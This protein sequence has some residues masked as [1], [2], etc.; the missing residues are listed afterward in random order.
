MVFE[1]R[2]PDERLYKSFRLYAFMEGVE[3]ENP[4][5][6]DHCDVVLD[7]MDADWF[8]G[9]AE[10]VPIA[11]EEAG[12]APISIMT[13]EESF[14][15]GPF[16]EKEPTGW[17]EIDLRTPKLKAAHYASLFHLPIERFVGYPRRLTGQESRRLEKATGL[18]DF[19]DATEEEIGEALDRAAGADDVAVCDIGHGNCNALCE[20]GGVV[21]Y[22]DFGGGTLWN[23]KTYPPSIRFCFTHD[24]PVILSHWDWD[25]W[26]SGDLPQHSSAQTLDWIVPRQPFFGPNHRRFAATVA[27]R[28]RLLIWPPGLTHVARGP[29][30]IVK[31][32]GRSRNDS[33]LAVYIDDPNPADDEIVQSRILLTGD[34]AYPDIPNAFATGISGMV[35]SHH[36]G[37]RSQSGVPPPSRPHDHK[38]VYSWGDG[39]RYKH[40][41]NG[42]ETEHRLA[43]WTQ[44]AHTANRGGARGH[45]RLA[46]KL[47]RKPACATST[48]GG[49]TCT[50]DLTK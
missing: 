22:F 37:N 47:P 16:T 50:L 21:A 6:G 4:R 43:G 25:H 24:P 38:L 29:L 39:N 2:P 41:T 30:E 14:R 23:V 26:A 28:G 18:D 27:A 34:A 11:F 5:P 48:C 20:G 45:V 19:S 40:P 36:G 49:S 1:P 8:D 9:R 33:G 10:G 42:N 17:W 15:R 44:D 31:C 7:A 35:A 12:E 32:T 13:V 3:P 46:G